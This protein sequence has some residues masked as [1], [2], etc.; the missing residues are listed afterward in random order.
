MFLI[1]FYTETVINEREETKVPRDIVKTD[2]D[3]NCSGKL[4]DVNSLSPCTHGKT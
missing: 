3:H 4:L 2:L 1:Y